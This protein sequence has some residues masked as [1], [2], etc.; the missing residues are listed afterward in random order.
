MILLVCGS[1]VH[2]AGPL[3]CPHPIPQLITGGLA[4]SLLRL[5]IHSTTSP[6][7]LRHQARTSHCSSAAACQ[8]SMQQHNSCHV[9]HL[10][11]QHCCSTDEVVSFALLNS[12]YFFRAE[13]GFQL[14]GEARGASVGRTSLAG[15][16]FQSDSAC[17]RSGLCQQAARWQRRQPFAIKFAPPA[18]E[19]IYFQWWFAFTT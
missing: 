9:K 17:L 6:S 5:Y 8:W 1:V 13:G 16:L 18:G 11:R 7:G 2:G 14:V 10:V 15:R 12:L 4:S 3:H 19:I